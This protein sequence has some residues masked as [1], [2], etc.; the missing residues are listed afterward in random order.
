MSRG[1]ERSEMASRRPLYPRRDDW[2]GVG[3]R[4]VPGQ[5][6]SDDEGLKGRWSLCYGDLRGGVR[7][8]S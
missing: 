7:G 2:I 5:S 3:L 6:E 4:F 1:K 8:T